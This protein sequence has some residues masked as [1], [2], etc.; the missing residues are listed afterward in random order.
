MVKLLF[1][2]KNILK[3]INLYLFGHLLP[4]IIPFYEFI[5]GEIEASES[6]APPLAFRLQKDTMVIGVKLISFLHH[7]E[8]D[9]HDIFV[10]LAAEYTCYCIIRHLQCPE[11]LVSS[12][13]QIRAIF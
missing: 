6:P 5:W 2:Y 12:A 1:R 7:D 11:A 10:H 8:W 13:A 9:Q 4:G 3:N